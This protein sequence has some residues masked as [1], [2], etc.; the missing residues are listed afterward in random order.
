MSQIFISYRR[1]CVA[2]VKAAQ[3]ALEAAGVKVW[4]DLE[5]IDPLADFPQRIR[6]GIGASHALLSWWSAD[7]AESD[8]CLQEFRLG[9]QHARRQNSDVARRVWVLN[10]EPDAAH[11]AAGELD[12][13][14]FLRP[15]PAGGEA[16]WA[17]EL[18][19]RLDALL[20]EGPLADERHLPPP[21]PLYGVPVGHRY[22]TGRNR[23]LMRIH[24]LSHPPRIGAQARDVAVQTHGL[25][26]VGKT[27][28]ALQYARGFADAYPGGVYWLNLTGFEP[29]RYVE[30][31]LRE[32]AGATWVAALEES[33]AENS[34]IARLLRDSEGRP[35]PANVV[36]GRMAQ[37]L[38]DAE[39]LWVLDNVPHFARQDLRDE[40]LALWRAP[41]ERGRSLVTTRDSAAMAGFVPLRL[42]MLG[43]EDGLRLL[44][45]HHRP[46]GPD[47]RHAAEK[48][49]VDLGGHPQ[50]LVLLARRV[51]MA[52][53]PF[54][55]RSAKER[56]DLEGV[57]PRIEAIAE[58][59]APQLGDKARGIVASLAL[60]VDL[61]DTQAQAMLLLAAAC[62][63]GV[64]IPREVLRTAFGGDEDDADLALSEVLR[65]S[66]LG[67]RSGADSH[68]VDIHGLVADAAARLL[69]PEGQRLHD[70]RD[71]VASVL[72]PR[73][74]QSLGDL[75][76]SKQLAE[77]AV[78][79]GHLFEHLATEAGVKLGL[80]L[81]LYFQ[82]GARFAEAL[83]I[84]DATLV[85]AR[86]VLGD[87]HPTTLTVMN[88]LASTLLVRGDLV[89][90]RALQEQLLPLYRRVFGYEHRAAHALMN[91]L[92]I[93]LRAQGEFAGA[94]ALH[95][96]QLAVNSRVL[97]TEHR[98]T[99]TTLNNLALTLQ[100][101]GALPEARA[102]LEQVYSIFRRKLGD[103]HPDTLTSMNNLAEVLR[104]QGDLAGALQ[105]QEQT[106][107]VGRRVFG[108]EHP[109][110]L[111]SINNLAGTLQAQGLFTLARP[112]QDEALAV[113]R[114]VLGEEHPSTLTSINN[115]A[116]TLLGQGDLP[117]A[118][119]LHEQELAICRR[120][121][122]D[123]HS[124]TLISMSN[125]ASTLSAQGDLAAARVLQE[126]VFTVF[127]RVLGDEHPDT[128]SSM[129]NLAFTLWGL[130]EKGEAIDLIRRAA[131]GRENKLGK[132]HAD[133]HKARHALETW[134][135]QL[136][137]PDSPTV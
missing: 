21:T 63:P 121:L 25:G 89:G 38:G 90:A 19:R 36:R 45:L 39:S 41:G 9:W 124:D 4:L 58:Q 80:G 79:A 109:R 107:A 132:E 115:L 35:L 106:L 87:E 129:S 110:T 81:G 26:G 61:L 29:G 52:A 56:I 91:N 120:V 3:A 40:V 30:A 114:K 88:N 66:L 112:L 49:V 33:C 102:L 101:Q 18:K 130:G 32:A 72:A 82:R 116:Q 2:E 5:E 44:A 24:S 97:G 16:A 75:T 76:S 28:L 15:P 103:E 96:Q 64:A 70:A 127:R 7:Y 14:N 108:D 57:L 46:V 122:G 100:A 137:A 13:E 93:T 59:L 37:R 119:A 78:H 31:G 118:R 54:A 62:A 83:D 51:A 92:A 94:R 22:F 71:L 53:T 73:L 133:S 68:C 55:Y 17:N 67:Q 136:A 98:T 85:R 10:P 23:E 123:E 12:S 125:L 126:Q 47:E 117:G 77:I 27:E 34:E 6:D 1:H 111:A 86:K 48:L 84:G 43:S 131:E 11:V 95:E 99:L 65:H 60:S 113:C 20:P 50:A 69:D 42:D 8:F 104:A 135:R 105:L 134:T 128:L 74:A